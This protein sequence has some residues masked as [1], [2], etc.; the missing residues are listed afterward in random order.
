MEGMNTIPATSPD[1]LLREIGRRIGRGEATLLLAHATGRSVAWLLAHGRD[2]LPEAACEAF[3]A[4]ADRRVEGVP[5]AYLV[6]S[7]GFWTLELKV[8]PDTLVPRPETELLVELAL[9]KL[10]PGLAARVLDLGTGSGAIALAIA[11]ERALA[12]VL[13]TDASQAALA[14]ARD[15]ARAHGIDNVRFVQGSWLAPVAGQRFDLIVSNPPYVADGDPHLGQ[16]DLRFE[17]ITALAAGHDGL[18]DLAQIVG[19]APAHLLPGGWLLLEHG[20]DQGAAV[21]ALL[22][23]AGLQE[24]RTA[25]DLEQRDRVSMGRAPS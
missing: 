8:T 19:A 6:G 25:P 21:R 11:R 20:W 24:T 3:A 9:D 22:A 7:K 1:A 2:A 18:R 16:G 10:P 13:A 4:L 15:N 17:P 5:V 12:C 23:Q 14:V